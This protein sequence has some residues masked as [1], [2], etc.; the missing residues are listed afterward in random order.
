ML[1]FCQFVKFYGFNNILASVFIKVLTPK[2][3]PKFIKPNPGQAFEILG[4]ANFL[5]KKN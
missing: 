3:K 4:Q 1:I 2:A 5:I